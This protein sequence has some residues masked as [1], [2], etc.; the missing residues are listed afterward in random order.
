MK[1]VAYHLL[2]GAIL[3]GMLV[4]MA[5][6]QKQGD[7][8][9]D[10]A[11]QKKKEKQTEPGPKKVYDNDNLPRQ[12]H[13][14]VVGR[15]SEEAAPHG[16]KLLNTSDDAS[17]QAAA[18]N[19]DQLADGETTQKDAQDTAKA[20]VKPGQ[21]SDDSQ[22]ADDEWPKKI[23]DQ[24]NALTLL[25]RELDVLQREYRLRAAAMYADAGNRL[26][27][28]EQWDKEDKQYKAQIDAKQ[29]AVDAAKQQLADLQE[30]ARR[31]GVP[32]KTRE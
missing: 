30:R 12:D 22:K 15:P 27:N 23:A 10:Y 3:A 4:T 13:I 18:P 29:K 20:D 8:L 1:R 32:A 31:A 14:N 6:A 5:A 16:A 9:A 24:K 17:P 28:A 11:R 26:R 25:Q 7:N 19:T 21:S 2:S